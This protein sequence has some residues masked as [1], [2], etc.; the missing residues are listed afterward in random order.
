[1]RRNRYLIP[2][3]ILSSAVIA[4]PALASEGGKQI[5]SYGDLDL[6]NP[7][8][9]TALDNRIASAVWKVCGKADPQDLLS[10]NRV[11]H[12]RTETLSD[13]QLQRS[14]VLAMRNGSI[15]VAARER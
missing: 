9:I 15:E 6:S 2:I 13:V 10:A 1:M 8:G 12:C 7:A 14:K 4:H 3:A 5:V 11:R